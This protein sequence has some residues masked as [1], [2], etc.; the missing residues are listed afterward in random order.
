MRRISRKDPVPFD[1]GD[2]V[3]RLNEALA[4]VSSAMADLEQATRKMIDLIDDLKRLSAD[5]KARYNQARTTTKG[6]K[7]TH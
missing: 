7:W 1:V 4:R 2:R 5:A 6:N 3:R